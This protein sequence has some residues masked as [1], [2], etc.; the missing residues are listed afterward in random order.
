MIT[1]PI[2]VPFLR[3]TISFSWTNIALAKPIADMEKMVKN[4]YNYYGSDDPLDL[5]EA[6]WIAHWY[7][8]EEWSQVISKRS[9]QS[10]ERLWSRGYFEAPLRYRLAFRE[11]GTTLGVQV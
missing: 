6:L 7:P 11:F 2:G 9:L 8:N 1:L 10:L 3:F 4:K 5:G